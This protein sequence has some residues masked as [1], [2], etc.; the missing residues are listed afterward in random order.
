MEE[1]HAAFKVFYDRHVRWL[2]WELK[3]RHAFKLLD[4]PEGAKDILQMVFCRVFEKAH[5]FKVRAGVSDPAAIRRLARAWVGKITNNIVAD[6]LRR[7]ALIP[8][9]E[10]P[11]DE[12]VPPEVER[13]PEEDSELAKRLRERIERLSAVEQDILF[14]SFEYWKPGVPRNQQRLPNGVARALAE[15]NGKTSDGIRQIRHR[16]FEKLFSELPMTEDE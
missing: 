11:P 3:R 13:E 5:L 9:D 7:P 12:A 8:V 10:D 4:W 16:L 15:R 2:Y 6:E 14:T 1:G